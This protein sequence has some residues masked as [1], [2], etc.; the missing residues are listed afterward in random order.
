MK[1]HRRI[2]HD[3]FRPRC[4]DLKEAAR[5]FH[6]LVANEIQIPFLWLANHLLIGN[7]SL[8]RRIPIDHPATAIDQAL[9]VKLDKDFLESGVISV[10]ERIALARPIARTA[11]SL[12]LSDD[13]AALL[14]LPYEVSP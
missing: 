14:V 2:S 10:I 7:G 3:R 1:R 4:C 5:F 8:R 13:D 11:E 9:V 6:N 12:K